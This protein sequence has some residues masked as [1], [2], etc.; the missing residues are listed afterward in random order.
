MSKIIVYTENH[1]PGGGNRYLIDFLLAIPDYIEVVL[2]SNKGA[3]FSEDILQLGSRFSFLEFSILTEAAQIK[4][5]ESNPFLIPILIAYKV[6]IRTPFLRAILIRLRSRYN[7]KLLYY[8]VHGNNFSLAIAFNGGFPSAIT[9]FDFL[10]ETLERKIPSVLS[11]VSMP[12]PYSFRDEIYKSVIQSIDGYIVNCE[13]IKNSLNKSRNIALE[14]FS[15]LYNEVVIPK[16]SPER[17]IYK[18][19]TNLHLGFIGRMEKSKGIYNLIEAF[20][21]VFQINSQ[22]TLQLFGKVYNRKNLNKAIID[23]KCEHAISIEGPF[24]GSV[25]EV[26]SNLDVLILPSL[27]EGF[28]YVI[29]EAMAYG[30]GVIATQV[31]GIPE[32][33]DDGKTGILVEAGD[34]EQLSFAIEKIVSD[35]SLLK[36]VREGCRAKI[37][38][39]FSTLM[40]RKNVL[41]ILEKFQE[42]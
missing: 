36:R 14:K 21:K 3:F 37:I 5:F 27:W 42:K 26:L 28:P 24:T 4:K 32:I 22:I 12:T 29:L 8:T 40:F 39:Q 18:P 7:R 1:E 20:G 19:G 9:C 15:V 34:I 17:K 16:L 11:V 31:G 6:V 13:A 23:T 33:I 10:A 25:Y 41:N 2:C 35:Q 30:V 38:E